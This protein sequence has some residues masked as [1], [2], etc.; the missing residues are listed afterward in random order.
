M[1]PY[2]Q[3]QADMLDRARRAAG[4]AA[5][6]HEGHDGY[7]KAMDN[8]AVQQVQSCVAAIAALPIQPDPFAQPQRPDAGEE[9]LPSHE[10]VRGI[11]GAPSGN[12]WQQQNDAANAD[13]VDAVATEINCGETEGDCEHGYT[14]HDT[15][16][17]VCP[18]EDRADQPLGCLWLAACRLRDLA[19]ELRARALSAP[20]AG[21]A[22]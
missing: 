10:D 22:P 18:Q 5:G 20:S 9:T 21:P 7:S 17:F 4:G 15:G 19:K 3:G 12:W 13:L 1:T 14:E 8:A 2:Q 6:R 16:G 11:L